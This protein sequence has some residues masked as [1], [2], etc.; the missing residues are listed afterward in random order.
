MRMINTNI[1]KLDLQNLN[2]SGQ[3]PGF[4]FIEIMIVV[5]IMAGIV[6]IVGPTLFS[7]LDEAKIDQASI[8]MKSIFAALDLYH[9]DNSVYPST[10]QGIE[11]LLTKPS[12]G[13]IP[14]KWQGPYLRGSQVPKDPWGF[15]Y[16]YQSDG[17]S[18][19]I[20]S[21]GADGAEGGEGINKDIVFNQ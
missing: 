1:S 13:I 5:V 8:Q 19:L 3:R 11:A 18:V 21:M 9:L 12:V 10:G 20:K 15:D 14:G 17:S 6:A 7:K 4:S 2:Q 16:F